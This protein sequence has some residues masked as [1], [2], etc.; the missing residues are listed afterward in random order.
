[1]ALRETLAIWV[2]LVAEAQRLGV[3]TSDLLQFAAVWLLI[4]DRRDRKG[5][6]SQQPDS[7]SAK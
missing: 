7:E 1:M 5:G 4:A 6:E 2:W 3:S